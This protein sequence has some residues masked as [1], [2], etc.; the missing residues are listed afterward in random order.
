MMYLIADITQTES[1]TTDQAD[2]D[3][4]AVVSTAEESEKPPAA[5]KSGGGRD[6][7]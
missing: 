5:E 3:G 1:S 6:P 4:S 2:T 7:Y